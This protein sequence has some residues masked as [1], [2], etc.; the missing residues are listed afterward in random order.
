MARGLLGLERTSSFHGLRLHAPTGPAFPGG[1]A[2]SWRSHPRSGRGTLRAGREPPPWARG[3]VLQRPELSGEVKSAAL[4]GLALDPDPTPHQ[5]H[6][7][8][9]DRESQPGSPYPRV[10]EPS[11]RVKAS[12]ISRCFSRGIPISVSTTVNWRM[13]VP[14]FREASVTR[15]LECQPNGPDC[16]RCEGFGV[17]TLPRGAPDRSGLQM[18]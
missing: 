11:A 2:G 14:P 15:A 8:R 9:G 13:Q 17:S 7:P 16:A 6:Q 10:V 3:A 4:A 1:F 12:N 5:P 18:R